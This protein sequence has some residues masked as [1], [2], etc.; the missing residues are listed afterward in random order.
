MS[1]AS[2]AKKSVTVERQT[3]TVGAVAALLAFLLGIAFSMGGKSTS[4]DQLSTQMT[5]MNNKLD[6]MTAKYTQSD[7]DTAVSIKGLEDEFLKL[8]AKVDDLSQQLADTQK[9]HR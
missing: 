8:N 9:G 3:L 1:D 7:K 4:I 5:I 6:T 2:Q